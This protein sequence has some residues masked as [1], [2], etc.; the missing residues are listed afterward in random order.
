MTIEKLRQHCEV[1]AV[2]GTNPNSIRDEHKLVLD[3]IIKKEKLN[4]FALEMLNNYEESIEKLSEKGL[5]EK[6]NIPFF[7]KPMREKLNKLL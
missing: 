3:L 4:K 1:M 6:I 7:I 2:R 5:I